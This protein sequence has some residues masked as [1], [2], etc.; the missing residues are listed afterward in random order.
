MRPLPA[1]S[2]S[3]NMNSITVYI[4]G[5]SRG[6]PGHAGV[7]VA[8]YDESGNNIKNV[9]KY[10]GKTTNN[11]AEYSALIAALDEAEQLGVQN[12]KIFLD[13]ELVYKQFT[14]EYK[15]KDENLKIL[16]AAIRNKVKNFK[17]LEI[18]HIPREK[19]KEADKLANIAVN[20]GETGGG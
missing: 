17:T 2:L 4:D 9:K 14:G 10:I 15:T 11:V 7:G 13:S 5:A 6:N 1:Y 3:K 18:M 19:N 20:L 16:L 8:I 12:I